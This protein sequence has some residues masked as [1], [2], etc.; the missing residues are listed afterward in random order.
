MMQDTTPA[1]RGMDVPVLVIVPAPNIERGKYEAET[2]KHGEYVV[3]DA[4]HAMFYEKPEEFHAALL[5]F[6]DRTLAKRLVSD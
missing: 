3:I 2:A 6:M 5:G 4:A 1:L